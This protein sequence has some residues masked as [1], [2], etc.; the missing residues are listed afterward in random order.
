MKHAGP[1]IGMPF[2]L[3]GA[4]FFV[5]AIALGFYLYG[6]NKLP[7]KIQKMAQAFDYSNFSPRKGKYKAKWELFRNYEMLYQKICKKIKVDGWSAVVSSDQVSDDLLKEIAIIDAASKMNLFKCDTNG[8]YCIPA[9]EYI[10]LKKK[11]KKKK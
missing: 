5:E 7:E 2:S 10:K 9:S 3:E 6:W 4:A 11:E 1:I 8:N